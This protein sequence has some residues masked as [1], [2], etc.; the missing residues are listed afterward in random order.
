MNERNRPSIFA[1]AWK[2]DENEYEEIKEKL[3][4]LWKKWTEKKGYSEGIE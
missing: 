4:N 2:M 3:K 1:G